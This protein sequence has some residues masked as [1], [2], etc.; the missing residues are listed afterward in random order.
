VDEWGGWYNVEE[1]TNPGFLYQQNTMRDAMIAGTTLNIFNNHADRVRVANLAQTVNVLQA[2]ILTKE[3]KMILTPTYHVMEMYN[4][5][6]DAKLIPI[7]V[8]SSDYVFGKE[9]LQ[10]VSASASVDKNG[11][12]H[13]SLVNIDPKNPQ[14]ITIDV[15]GA[16]YK[17]VTGR[18]LTSAKLQDYNSFEQ[19]EKIKPGIF[20]DAQL[21]NNTLQVKLP[22]FSVVV[23]EVK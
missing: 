11:V 6:Q 4:V 19:P 15:N 17:S 22:P 9:K 21:K 7:S 10:A 8:T 23:L 16:P 14:Q 20:K 13:I 12:T 3:E 18:V 5:H 1:G 2:V